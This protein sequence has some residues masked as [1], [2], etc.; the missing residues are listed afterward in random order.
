MK[1]VVI[2]CVFMLL[3]AVPEVVLGQ[4]SWVLLEEYASP[5]QGAR[6]LY[7]DGKLLWNVDHEANTVFTL[8]PYNLEV[9]DIYPSPINDPWGI[10]NDGNNFWMTKFS[11]TC[12]Q[13]VKIQVDTFA[14]ETYYNFPGYYFYGMT[15]GNDHLW[16]SAMN[17]SY[18]KY[19]LEFDPVS[20]QV[21]QWH[22]WSWIWPL[23]Q[24]FWAGHLWINSSDWY[25]PDYTYLLNLENWT[26]TDMLICPMSVPEGIATNGL[27]WWI[28]HFRNNAP[29]IWKLIPPNVEVHDIAAHTPIFPTSG[30][31][32]TLFFEPQARFINY[33]AMDEYD[34]PFICQIIED[35]SET[36]V[37]YDSLIYPEI[38]REEIVD[39]AFSW[40]FLEPNT[41]YTIHFYSH[42]ITDGYRSNDS[43]RVYVYT[44]TTGSGP[45]IRDLAILSVLEP[46]S[47]E[48]LAPITPAIRVQNQGQVAESVAPVHLTIEHP[49]GSTTEYDGQV[50]NLSI[51]EIDTLYF[52]EFI[53]PQQGVY[54][55]T[56]DGLLPEDSDP[57]NDLVVF[58]AQIGL[59]H[60]VTPVAVLSPQLEE[61]LGSITP[62]VVVQNLG[63]YPENS[64]YTSCIIAD[65]SAVV[66]FQLGLCQQLATNAQAEIAFPA[67]NPPAAGLYTFTFT[68]L[69]NND[70][71]R[72]NDTLR[73]VS[74]IG[75][76]C[77]VAPTLILQPTPTL[78][79]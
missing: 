63:D 70:N 1:S 55:F 64:F 48:P 73:V 24:Q 33:G 27:E 51:N 57:L 32:Q 20:G 41:E 44:D 50:S 7:Y 9:I 31:L 13:I 65:C 12:S 62:R 6:E 46:D 69:L 30:N 22:N 61:P 21:V 59:I 15:Y 3:L 35:S 36:L 5:G 40:A 2:V 71:I 53:P 47:S 23:G 78:T 11:N 39:L 42:L 29:Y 26:I 76:V 4:Q 75:L 77:D 25:Y 54:T 43:L 38:E 79:G 74:E 72:E 8:N 14:V 60:D 45:L 68:T 28:S 56:F 49:E 19:L 10:T 58:E 67:Y 16:I 17:H 34:V 66:Y 52:P 18:V 37:Y